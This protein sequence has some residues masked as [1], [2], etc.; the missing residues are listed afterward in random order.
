[1]TSH[2]LIRLKAAIEKEL[3]DLNALK[4]ETSE[5]EMGG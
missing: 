2:R 1:M 3:A 5:G 4:Q